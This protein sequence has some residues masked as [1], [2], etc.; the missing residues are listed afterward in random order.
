MTDLPVLMFGHRRFI[1]C[2]LLNVTELGKTINQNN[3]LNMK[4]YVEDY[5]K[6][7]ASL[8][9][10]PVD[11]EDRRSERQTSRGRIGNLSDSFDLAQETTGLVTENQSSSGPRLSPEYPRRSRG[12]WTVPLGNPPQNDK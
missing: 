3:I 2:S 10:P 5:H 8:N 12:F 4:R 6:F 9:V 11:A 7:V 1:S